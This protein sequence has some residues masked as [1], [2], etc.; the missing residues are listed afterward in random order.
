MLKDETALTH[1]YLEPLPKELR[2]FSNRRDLDSAE[3]LLAE[4][5]NIPK[6]I[7]DALKCEA[8]LV[9]ETPASMFVLT[10][11]SNAAFGQNPEP[12]PVTPAQAIEF[13]QKVSNQGPDNFIASA[14]A[15]LAPVLGL[16]AQGALNPDDE[17]Q[18]LRRL[19]LRLIII[20]RARLM[21]N[22]ADQAVLIEPV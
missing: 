8:P 18:A 10:A 5:E 13:G 6:V 1:E 22:S 11:L 4:A 20:G 15:V 14:I 3:L 19:V 21:E 2:A 16:K 7:F 17:P 9:E 12:V